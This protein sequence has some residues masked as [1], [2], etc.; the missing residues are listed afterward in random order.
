LRPVS[1][2]ANTQ[3]RQQQE[4]IERDSY[5]AKPELGG[6]TYVAE[7]GPRSGFS[8]S[9]WKEK[10][11]RNP[12]T[13]APPPRWR[14]EP[15]AWAGQLLA[16]MVTANSTMLAATTSGTAHGTHCRSLS[17]RCC[18]YGSCCVDA[19]GGYFPSPYRPP[20]SMS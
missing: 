19:G 15:A 12:A 16:Y 20:F 2:E 13:Q 14:R 18:G 1:I 10:R 17:S 9:G 8:L 3:Q 4:P 5:R 7:E 11:L 6:R